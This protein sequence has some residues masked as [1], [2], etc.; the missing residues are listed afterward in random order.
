MLDGAALFRIKAIEIGVSDQRGR[1]I[2]G[3]GWW[4]RMSIGLQI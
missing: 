4:S 1:I 2:L 3:G